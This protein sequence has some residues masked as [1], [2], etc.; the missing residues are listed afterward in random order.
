MQPH[1]THYIDGRWRDAIG[2]ERIE[3]RN[4][5]T[6]QCIGSVPAAIYFDVDAAVSAAREALPTWRDTAPHERAAALRR[7]ADGLQARAEEIAQCIRAEMGMPIRM[8]RRIQATLP[9]EVFRATAAALDDFAFEEHIGHSRV[10]RTAVGVVACITPWNYPLH[11]IAAKVAPALA[12]GCTVVLKPSELAP[13]DARIFAEVVD[14]AGLPAGVFNLITGLGRSTGASLVAH[15]DVD[16]ISFTGSTAAGKLV[17]GS[18]ARGIKRVALELGGKSASVVLAGADLAGAVRATVNRCM[19][20]SGQTCNALTR[21]LVPQSLYAEAARIAVATA[22]TLTVGDPNDEASKLGPLV[23][24]AQAARVRQYIG[25][26]LADGAELLCGGLE[27]P[28][29]LGGNYVQPTV[30]G[31]VSPDSPLAQDEVFGP[32]LAIL[33]YPDGDEE[34]AARIANGTRYG[35]AAAVWAGSDDH[36]LAFGQRLVAG[37]IDLNGGAFNVAA[38]MGGFRQSGIGRELGRYGIEEFLETRSFQMP[39][40]SPP[41]PAQRQQAAHAS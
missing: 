21:L 30:F 31:R 26:A 32:V 23:S 16:A 13:L 22:A 20:N 15:P 4:P 12:A 41:A 33:T 35:L 38:P 11:Q 10:A 7:I 28:P 6:G 25:G 8:A 5:A 34:A 18:A 24:A 3:V 19:L 37:Q 40:A 27:P 29:G 17:A 39:A 36:A 14:A 9:V 2:P 1:T